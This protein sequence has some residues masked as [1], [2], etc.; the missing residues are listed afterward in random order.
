MFGQRGNP[1]DDI[2]IFEAVASQDSWKPVVKILVSMVLGHLLAAPDVSI[3]FS[4]ICS[5]GR[6]RSVSAALG[7]T[8]VLYRLR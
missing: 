8:N 1:A 3:C 6:Q 2:R 7:M 4:V 5:H